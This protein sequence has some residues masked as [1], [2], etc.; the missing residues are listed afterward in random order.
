MFGVRPEKLRELRERMEALGIREE[1]IL[2]RFIRSGGPGGQK[3]N[4]ASTCVY[5]KHLPTGIE[6]K[7]RESRSQPLNRFLA[8]R[9]LTEKIE[10]KLLGSRSP[11]ERLREKIRKQKL[12]RRKRARR[13][14]LTEG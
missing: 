8:R 6:V 13:K 7:C 9:Y 10:Q 4:K 3:V 2:E 11:A 5:L 12:K 1:D 14:R